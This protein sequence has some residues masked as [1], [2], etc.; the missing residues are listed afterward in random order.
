[1]SF[2]FF[3]FNFFPENLLSHDVR[4]SF[5][6]D[7]S[8]DVS[9][10]VRLSRVFTRFWLV[11]GGATIGGNRVKRAKPVVKVLGVTRYWSQPD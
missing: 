7:Y 11:R 3:S 2:K 4:I 8:I 6:E 1:V 9:V 10:D 5:S